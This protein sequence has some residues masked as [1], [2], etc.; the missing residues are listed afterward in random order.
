MAKKAKQKRAT[1]PAA[2]Q[3]APAAGHAAEPAPIGHKAG[4]ENNGGAGNGDGKRPTRNKFIQLSDVIHRAAQ[5][6]VLD[7]EGLDGIEVLS[8]YVFAVS[9]FATLGILLV[10]A[11]ILA[12]SPGLGTDVL[13]A[14]L[15]AALAVRIAQ[16][17]LTI[18]AVAV[19][20]SLIARFYSLWGI[21]FG[22]VV[23]G[24]LIVPANEIVRFVLLITGSER[25]YEDF[26]RSEVSGRVKAITSDGV[27]D[28]YIDDRIITRISERISQE[29]GEIRKP[30]GFDQPATAEQHHA[31]DLTGNLLLHGKRGIAQYC[32][33]RRVRSFSLCRSR[34]DRLHS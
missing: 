5:R 25:A 8:A 14:N 18:T 4:D 9:A 13:K 19:I 27:C 21:T 10:G 15:S 22:L 6:G 33:G 3:A 30:R 11:L 1:K 16:L 24:A 7:D 2:A 29:C 20:T 17:A 12:F 28:V 23:I 34:G 31:D 26:Y 32:G